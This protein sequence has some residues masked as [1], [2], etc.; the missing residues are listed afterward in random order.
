M[1]LY[2]MKSKFSSSACDDFCHCCT[3]IDIMTSGVTRI[4]TVARRWWGSKWNLARA[5]LL[6]GWAQSFGDG[7][8]PHLA[9]SP[10]LRH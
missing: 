1:Q 9:P 3:P 4:L 6:G 10:W 5:T 2:E 8:E 7:A